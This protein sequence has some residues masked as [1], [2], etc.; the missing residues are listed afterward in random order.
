[1]KNLMTYFTAQEVND[2]LKAGV[3]TTEDINQLMTN[4]FDNLFGVQGR[5]LI[6]EKIRQVRENPILKEKFSD[7]AVWMGKFA[8]TETYFPNKYN[9][10]D[11]QKWVNKYNDFFDGIRKEV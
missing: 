4:K 10:K 2:L 1:M 6:K 7:F 5:A 3:F 8:V 11:V 9:R